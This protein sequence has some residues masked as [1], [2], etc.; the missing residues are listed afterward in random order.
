MPNLKL[1]RKHLNNSTLDLKFQGCVAHF[2]KHRGIFIHPYSVLACDGFLYAFSM[3]IIWYACY[4]GYA[5]PTSG[6][7]IARRGRAKGFSDGVPVARPIKGS[8]FGESRV[9]MGRK[10][11]GDVSLEA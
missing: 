4:R 7:D 10:R 8:P 2:F 11:K 3:R 6:C 9:M 1:A 5:L